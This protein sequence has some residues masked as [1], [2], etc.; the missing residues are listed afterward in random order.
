MQSPQI[1][2]VLKARELILLALEN[3][4]STTLQCLISLQEMICNLN[5]ERLLEEIKKRE[6]SK[7]A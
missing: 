2:A 4:D 5:F 1:K 6:G 7:D 3:A